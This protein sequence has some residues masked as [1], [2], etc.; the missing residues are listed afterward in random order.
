MKPVLNGT[1]KSRFYTM[2]CPYFKGGNFKENG[3][4][5]SYIFQKL[6]VKYTNSGEKNTNSGEKIISGTRY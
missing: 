3:I 6:L 4:Y 5:G 1:Y 2:E